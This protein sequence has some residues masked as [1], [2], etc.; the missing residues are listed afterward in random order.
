[1]ARTPNL[2]D[3]EQWRRLVAKQAKSGLTVAEFCAKEKISQSVFYWRRRVVKA[4]EVGSAD[5]QKPNA[6]KPEAEVIRAGENA[7]SDATASQGRTDTTT[8]T[9]ILPNGVRLELPTEDLDLVRTVLGQLAGPNPDVEG[10]IAG[11]TQNNQADRSS[12]SR[13]RGSRKRRKK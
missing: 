3:R 1:M 13:G 8:M 11:A 5:T 2:K 6:A 12:P 10:S 4:N 7:R 9:I